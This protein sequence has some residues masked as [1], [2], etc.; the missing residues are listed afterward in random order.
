MATIL[1]I[2]GSATAALVV[3]LSFLLQDMTAEQRALLRLPTSIEA[4]QN[5][6]HALTEYKTDHFWHV[7]VGHAA[8]YFYFQSFGIPGTFIF[9]LL[10]GA[11]FGIEIAFPMCLVYNTLGSVFMYTISQRL[12]K[13]ITQNFFPRR[14]SEFKAFVDSHKDTLLLRMISLRLLPFSPNW[15]INISCGQLHVPVSMFALSILIGLAP[16]NFLSCEAGLILSEL[17][18]DGAVIDRRKT[19]LLA[20]IAIV[21][22]LAPTIA[23]RWVG[24]PLESKKAQ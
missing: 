21:G 13:R 20:A 10:A 15:F 6:G 24:N 12:G 2:F 18:S 9:N 16:Y 22:F 19:A 8:C 3:L 23:K 17:T 7:V 1:L 11:L 14:F 5:I 4:G